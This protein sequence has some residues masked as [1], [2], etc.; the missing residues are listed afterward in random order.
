MTISEEDTL[1][2]LYR[3][4]TPLENE[5]RNSLR[6][7][8]SDSDQIGPGRWIAARFCGR[9]SQLD[10]G[11]DVFGD[12][13]QKVRGMELGMFVRLADVGKQ[14]FIWRKLKAWR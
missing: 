9:S 4:L 7:V 6:L 8:L 14:I 13:L 12:V 10:F 2:V 3:E 1:T 11:P 5:R